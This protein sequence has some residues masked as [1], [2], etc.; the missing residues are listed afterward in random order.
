M[1]ESPDVLI[2][3]AGVAGLAAAA[4]LTRAGKRVVLLEARSRIGGRVWTAGTTGDGAAVELGAEFV[5]GREH[6]M[7]HLL[8]QHRLRIREMQGSA[9]CSEQG[10]I[11]HCDLFE[12]VERVFR[13]M[14]PSAPDVSFLNFLNSCGCGSERVRQH[15]FNFV[16]GFH[17]SDA[18]RV[19]VHSLIESMQAEHETEGDRGFRLVG[20]YEQLIYALQRDVAPA[21]SVFHLGTIVEEV[22]WKRGEVEIRAHAGAA[23][24]TFTA[25]R[26]LITL[27]LGA[28][29]AR[30]SDL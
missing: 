19:S 13:K 16:E 4:T 24:R 5:H 6:E 15:A 17:A 2:I 8:E 9:W 10:R 29:Q 21:R 11:S 23:S 18:A 7:A 27:P 12:D 22:N 14:D 30:V 20:G 26:A 28:L 25:E 3:G 1:N